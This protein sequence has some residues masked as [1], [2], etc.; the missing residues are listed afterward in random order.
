MGLDGTSYLYNNPLTCRGGVTRK[1]WYAIPCCPSNISRTW[2]D[3]GNYIYSSSKDE[4]YIHQYINSQ[5]ENIELHSHFPWDG[6]VKI[7]VN[8][9]AQLTLHLRL[10]SWSLNPQVKVNGQ[11]LEV[12]PTLSKHKTASGY[13]PRAS[14]I[15]SISRSW[16]ANDLIEISFDM[17]IQ[18]HHAHPKVKG[19]QGKAAVTRGPLVYCLESIDNPNVDIFNA[20]MDTTSLQPVFEKS[21]LGGIMKI[22]GRSTTGEP[23]TFIPYFLWG[24]RGESTMTVWVNQ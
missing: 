15:L 3:L 14:S 4:I 19:H 20:K 2:A 9:S 18:I 16:S 24:N 12:E 7:K 1:P 13:D 6:K 10:P 21:M 8:S 23:L 11:G 17:S 5:F 22:E